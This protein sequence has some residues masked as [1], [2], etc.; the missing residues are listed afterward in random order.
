MLQIYIPKAIEQSCWMCT[1]GQ[2]WSALPGTLQPSHPSLNHFHR[3]FFPVFSCPFSTFLPFVNV[4]QLDGTRASSVNHRLTINFSY[5]SEPSY[6]LQSS[7]SPI[8]PF[9]RRE[10]RA[11]DNGDNF[12]S[13]DNWIC[14]RECFSASFLPVRPAAALFSARL[15]ISRQCVRRVANCIR[16]VM[17][18][19]VLERKSL[20]NVIKFK[21]KRL[22][23]N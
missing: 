3:V 10:K 15:M 19:R 17:W 16:E 12:I 22:E 4:T 7:S 14:Y 1:L 9:G 21:R 23:C 11:D 13:P 18:S 20:T 8:F 2:D 6:W 5:H